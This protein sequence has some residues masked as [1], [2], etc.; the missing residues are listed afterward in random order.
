[1]IVKSP[2]YFTNE[3][4]FI[5][6]YNSMQMIHLKCSEINYVENML[7]FLGILK[8]IKKTKNYKKNIDGKRFVYYNVIMVYQIPNTEYRVNKINISL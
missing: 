2:R 1:M 8:V 3:S 7:I 4:H 5:A 6:S